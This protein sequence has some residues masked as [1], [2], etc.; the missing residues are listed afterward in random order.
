MQ[1]QGTSFSESKPC[2]DDS[3][4]ITPPIGPSKGGARKGV[5]TTRLHGIKLISKLINKSIIIIQQKSINATP[6]IWRSMTSGKLGSCNPSEHISNSRYES[7]QSINKSP[8][9]STQ[10]QRG[11]S[12]H[13]KNRYPTGIIFTDSAFQLEFSIICPQLN[14]VVSL[15]T[16]CINVHQYRP[17]TI[18]QT[19]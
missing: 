15:T 12:T 13:D 16:R 4:H 5:N 9:M 18:V 19:K 6:A 10:G 8:A 2:G 7:I 1:N 3:L 11:I 14:H 17:H